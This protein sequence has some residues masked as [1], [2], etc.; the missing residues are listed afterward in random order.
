MC[1][2]KFTKIILKQEHFPGIF[3]YLRNYYLFKR[4]HRDFFQEMIWGKI[5]TLFF[6]KNS[7]RLMHYI[8]S[9]SQ[10]RV[11]YVGR[12]YFEPWS[13]HGRSQLS[14]MVQYHL[15]AHIFL[16]SH[17]FCMTIRIINTIESKAY[18]PHASKCIVLS[19]VRVFLHQQSRC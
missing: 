3:Q 1:V 7:T 16:G 4:F 17:G 10:L 8:Y 13:I 2:R 18:V 5:L 15:F 9:Q 6:L 12:N 11:R 19:K 14:S